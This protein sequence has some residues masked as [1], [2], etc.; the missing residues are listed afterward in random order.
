MFII[1]LVFYAGFYCSQQSHVINILLASFARSAGQAM[2]PRFF[3]PC[4]HKM[5]WE[6]N[7]GWVLLLILVVVLYE[8]DN[9]V[10]STS[11]FI[12]LQ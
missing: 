6:V 11:T 2:D 9:L 4:L 7:I 10:F 12:Q 8:K 5:G 1:H 3:F